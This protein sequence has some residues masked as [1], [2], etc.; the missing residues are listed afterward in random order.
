MMALS[1]RRRA[2]REAPASEAPVAPAAVNA[3]AAPAAGAAASKTR[4][5]AR[6]EE[7]APAATNAGVAGTDALPSTTIVAAAPSIAAPA[8]PIAQRSIVAADKQEEQPTSS[9]AAFAS[10][11]RDYISARRP[12]RRVGASAAFAA[13]AEPLRC[14]NDEV[15]EARAALAALPPKRANAKAQRRAAIEAR[16]PQWREWMR[17]VWS[18][19]KRERERERR[20]STSIESAKKKETP[21]SI[22]C[23]FSPL[24]SSSC[25]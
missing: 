18:W 7:A 10:A 24:N 3:P 25:S 12:G 4:K 14:S 9:E 6:V 22:P 15:E 17:Y 8:P 13:A 20:I 21:I 5:R 11:H 19:E 2:P 1:S 23:F 16:F